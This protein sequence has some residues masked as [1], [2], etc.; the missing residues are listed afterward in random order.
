MR[1]QHYLAKAGIA[2]RRK[3]EQMI[4]DG[5]VMVNGEIILSMGKKVSEDDEIRVDGKIVKLSQRSMTVMYYKPR[6]IVCTNSD[7]K[8]RKCIADVIS[9]IPERLYPVGR[10]DMNSEGLLLL[11]NDGELALRITHPKYGIQKTYVAS[12]EGHV[13]GEAIQRLRRG[14][15]IDERR[16]AP[17]KVIRIQTEGIHEKLEITIH[18][19]RNRQIRK[20]LETVGC[21]VVRLVRI[22]AGPLSLKGLKP[23]QWRE[24][25]ESELAELRKALNFNEMAVQ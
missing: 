23:G 10:L 4:S 22:S 5:R 18:E 6:G 24:L 16:T 17:A 19:G 20:M 3:S 21:R 11:T 14:V 15:V 9:G 7:E 25:T 13:T 8:G 12:I 1:L 2:S